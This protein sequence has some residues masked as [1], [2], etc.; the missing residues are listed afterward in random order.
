MGEG[1]DG[2]VLFDGDAVKIKSLPGAESGGWTHVQVGE[3][4]ATPGQFTARR[5][6][7]IME[8]LS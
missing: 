3:V 5:R 8:D 1:L 7:A 6:I 2:A 4:S